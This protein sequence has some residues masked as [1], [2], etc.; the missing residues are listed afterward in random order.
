MVELDLLR[1]RC[2]C[3]CVKTNIKLQSYNLY[4][5]DHLRKEASEL[6]PA[7]GDAVAESWRSSLENSVNS[8]LKDHYKYGVSSVYGTS[9]NGNVTLI[10]CIESHQ[11]QPHNFWLVQTCVLFIDV[12]DIPFYSCMS[13]T[14][15]IILKTYWLLANCSVVNWRAISRSSPVFRGFVLIVSIF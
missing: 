1:T 11:Y 4:R 8:Y 9:A 7:Q 12:D 15:S 5:Y 6:H 3:N 13:S 10:A 14:C 2:C